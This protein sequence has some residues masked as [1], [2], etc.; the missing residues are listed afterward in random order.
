MRNWFCKLSV[1]SIM[2]LTF[3][4]YAAA[5][6]AEIG[7]GSIVEPI[8][9]SSP[10]TAT[11]VGNQPVAPQPEPEPL[12]DF[13]KMQVLENEVMQLRGLVEELS[14]E[15]RQLKQRQMDDYIDL[16]RRISSGMT[17]N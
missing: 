13:S 15:V 5:P 11:T 6:V 2:A 3:N 7:D 4:V 1:L 10:Y 12:D 14:N 17:G 9:D 16:D 8:A